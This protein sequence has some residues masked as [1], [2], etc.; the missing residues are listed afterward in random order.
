MTAL[1]QLILLLQVVTQLLT[2][3]QQ[4][5]QLPPVFRQSVISQAQKVIELAQKAIFEEQ[6]KTTP[7]PAN[8]TLIPISS[9]V[10]NL[11]TSSSYRIEPKPNYDLSQLAALIHEK[12]NYERAQKGLGQLTYNLQL[13]QIAQTHSEDQTHDNLWS[14]DIDKPCSYIFIRH[15]G[16]LDANSSLGDRLKSAS[17]SFREAREN[18][19]GIGMS[20]HLTYQRKAD[21]G[22]IQCPE[23]TPA[24]I[25]DHATSEETQEIIRS[26]IALSKEVFQPISPIT[27]VNREWLEIHKIA[28]Q[29]V[30][31]WMNSPG[32]KENLLA[33]D[34]TETGIGTAIINEYAIITQVFIKR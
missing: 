8:V 12:I 19:A 20:E 14:T 30:T 16:S 21:E 5:P 10:S 25:S 32:H 11:A 4:R 27:W 33:P 31:G 26:H 17:V 24:P 18:I 28:S 34:V 6:K 29:A 1:T 13:S 15:Q 22:A 23:F 3:V 9:P 7:T 2:A